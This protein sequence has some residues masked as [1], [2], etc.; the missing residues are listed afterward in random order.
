MDINNAKQSL[1]SEI[2]KLARKYEM[3]LSLPEDYFE[4]GQMENLDQ[5]CGFYDENNQKIILKTEVK[6]LRYEGRTPRLEKLCIGDSVL[7][8]RE[9][10][11]IYN[12]NNF[13]V[14][15]TEGESLGNLSAE[16]P[17]RRHPVRYS[18]HAADSRHSPV[19][20]VYRRASPYW[21]WT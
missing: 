17:Y 12:S 11:N 14:N 2:N 5:Y 3:S 20:R 15:T 9:K 18:D 1:L 7:I 16:H 8:T 10:S 6:G 4:P 21:T 13:M 19:F